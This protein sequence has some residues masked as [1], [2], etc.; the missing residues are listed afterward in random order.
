MREVVI[1]LCFLIL[2]IG[3]YVLA[4]RIG[5]IIQE[6]KRATTSEAVYYDDIDEEAKDVD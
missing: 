1:V 6:N 4:E 5:S 3:G 2:A